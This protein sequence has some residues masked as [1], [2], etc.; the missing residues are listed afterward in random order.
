M[1]E[2]CSSLSPQVCI[3]LGVEC[4]SCVRTRAHA[5]ARISPGLSPTEAAGL[6]AILYPS[7]G[8]APMRDTFLIDYRDEIELSFAVLSAPN[9]IRSVA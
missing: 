5:L 1:N 2:P 4:F 3:K 8:C 6:F 7:P 9:G